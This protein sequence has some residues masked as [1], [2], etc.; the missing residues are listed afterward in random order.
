MA[1]AGSSKEFVLITD[2]DS[3][4]FQRFS[5]IY[6]EALPSSERKPHA[7]VAGLAVRKDYHIIGLKLDGEVVSF[8]IL[9]TSLTQQV[10]LLEY[11]ATDQAH[12]NKHLG[13]DMFRKAVE[14]AGSFPLLVEVDSER[15]DSEDREIRIRRKSFYLRL[16]CRQI[17][18]LDYLMPQVGDSVPPT[19]DLLVH[20]SDVSELPGCEQ[21]RLWLRTIY[22][23]VYDCR[24]DD[25]RIDQ[26]VANLEH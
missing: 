10:A 16:G 11:M 18:R 25:S 7:A 14:I 24:S 9:F 23:E 13:A 17:P 15:E 3:T 20:H 19:M 26:M 6:E 8:L 4:E 21:V 22:K 2:P 1:V 12:R 5:Q